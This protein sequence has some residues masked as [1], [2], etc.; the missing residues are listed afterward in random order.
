MDKAFDLSNLIDVEIIE[1]AAS[2][3]EL[4]SKR[5]M[6]EFYQ[7]HEKLY[8][9]CARNVVSEVNLKNMD[10]NQLL[11]DIFQEM[12]VYTFQKLKTYR[13]DLGTAPISFFSNISCFR[14]KTRL[15]ELAEPADNAYTGGWKKIASARKW[16]EENDI[17]VNDVNLMNISGLE[18]HS[19][20][21]AI[22]QIHSVNQDRRGHSG[23][24]Y[25]Q[26]FPE[27][28]LVDHEAAFEDEIAMC[29]DR[30]MDVDLAV[31]RVYDR[32]G[33]A[34]PKEWHLQVLMGMY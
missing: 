31:Q 29:I 25:I 10:A 2:Q 24:A 16:L 34:E 26:G 22:G 4:L 32:L 17:E 23:S 28:A 13:K 1:L 15:R 18:E 12:W 20:Y 8:W 6:H 21:L 30:D 27:E 5:A 14:A 33:I 19:Y 3:D 9:K 7:R 11:D